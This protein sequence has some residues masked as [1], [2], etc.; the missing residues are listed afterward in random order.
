MRHPSTP[1]KMRLACNTWYEVDGR[2]MLVTENTMDSSHPGEPHGPGVLVI[3]PVL[4]L[5]V[6]KCTDSF[7]A[8][9]VQGSGVGDVGVSGSTEYT[10]D[11][12]AE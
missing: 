3:C 8:V 7:V 9:G 5:Q 6:E 11:D 1:C 12:V 10:D 4:G 2:Y